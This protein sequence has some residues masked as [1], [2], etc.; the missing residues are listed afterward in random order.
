MILL[1]AIDLYGGKAVRLYKGDYAQMTVYSERPCEVAADF[2]ACGARWVH[3]VDLEGARGGETPNLALIAEIVRASGLRA[4]VGGGVRSMAVVERYAEAGVSRVVLGTAAVTDPDFLEQAVRAYGG[5]IAVGVDI[6]DGF[7]AIRG[8]T[9]QSAF[10]AVDFCRRMEDMGVETL[11]CTDISRDGAMR[12]TNMALYEELTGTLKR[13]RVM[14]SGGVSSLEDVRG[15]RAAGLYGAIVGKAYY[16]GAI[17]LRQAL[18]VA[19]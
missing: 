17:D 1:P 16:T 5:L 12:G 7:V 11:V 9:E 10:A 19:K 8:W 4:E 18:E 14:A 15:L 3:L 13:T 6:R 2:A